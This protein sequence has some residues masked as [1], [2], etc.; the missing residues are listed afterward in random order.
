MPWWTEVFPL[1]HPAGTGGESIGA[2]VA[3]T[4]NAI[5]WVLGATYIQGRNAHVIGANNR[6]YSIGQGLKPGDLNLLKQ[7]GINVGGGC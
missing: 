5:A 1:W 3:Q 4:T 2:L 6:G 7:G